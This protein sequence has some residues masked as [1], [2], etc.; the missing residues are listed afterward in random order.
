MTAPNFR[1]R[2]R[3]QHLAAWDDVAEVSLYCPRGALTVE[4]LE[5]GPFDPRPDL[6]VLSTQGPGHYRLRVFASGRDRDFDKVV[7]DSAERFHVVAWPAP[8]APALIV[9]ATSRCGYGFRLSAATS[10]PSP[11]QP[12]PETQEATSHQAMLDR[13]LRGE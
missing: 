13:A 8:A 3:H 4:R 12:F 5:Y 10:P 7:D 1:V 11:Q 6:P 9:K 2:C